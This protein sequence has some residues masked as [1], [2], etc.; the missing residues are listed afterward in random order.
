MVHK[1][2][3]RDLAVASLAAAAIA[4][5]LTGC[6]NGTSGP[7]AGSPATPGAPG[8]S[9]SSNGVTALAPQV[10]VDGQPQPVTGGVTCTKSG[11]NVTIGIGDASNGVGAVVSTD[12]PP[13]VHTV[14]LGAVSGVTL[15]YSDA[16]PGQVSRAGAAAS[17]NSYTIK[18][19]ATGS[20]L[21][22]PQAP[23]QISKSFEMDVT[24]P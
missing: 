24:C 4:P 18:G 23:Q 12:N 7:N 15:G 21:S 19:T 17:G 13:L 20:D 22:N 10:V 2:I 6:S 8:S 3:Q 9:A 1:Q 16:D 14:G 11:N 5:G